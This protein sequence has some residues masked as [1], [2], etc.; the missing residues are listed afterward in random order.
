MQASTNI[1]GIIPMNPWNEFSRSVVKIFVL[2]LIAVGPNSIN[3]PI[4]QISNSKINGTNLN[5][6]EGILE[7]YF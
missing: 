3:T 7:I 5:K 6:I 1:S 4:L 2:S